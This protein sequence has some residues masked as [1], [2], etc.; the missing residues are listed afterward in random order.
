MNA[1]TPNDLRPIRPHLR[2]KRRWRMRLATAAL[3]LGGLLGLWQIVS[4]AP[5]ASAQP[6]TTIQSAEQQL[7]LGNGTQSWFSPSGAPRPPDVVSGVS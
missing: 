6:E 7:Q 3:S 4:H 5:A 2:P 1:E